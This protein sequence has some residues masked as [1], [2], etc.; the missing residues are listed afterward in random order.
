VICKG[1]RQLQTKREVAM[2]WSRNVAL[3]TKLLGQER[4]LVAG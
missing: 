1:S 4:A 3:C 2:A